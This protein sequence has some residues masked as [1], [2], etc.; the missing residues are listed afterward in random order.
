MF[1]DRVVEI[2]GGVGSCVA[3]VGV[4]ERDQSSPTTGCAV[5]TL[6]C[7]LAE[8]WSGGAGCEFCLL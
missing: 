7:I 5:L 1:G 6:N 2:G 8:V 4:D 3:D